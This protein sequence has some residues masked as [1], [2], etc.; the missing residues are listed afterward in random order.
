MTIHVNKIAELGGHKGAV[1]TLEPA[2][3]PNLFFSGSSDRVSALWD[4]GTNEPTGF[5]AQFPSIVF[6]LC[7][8]KGKNLLLTGTSNGSL[9]F[10]NLDKK[11][12]IKIIQLTESGTNKHIPGIFDIKFHE[13]SGRIFCAGGDGTFS[14]C[15]LATMSMVKIRKLCTEKTRCIEINEARKEIAVGCGDGVIWIFDLHTLEEKKHF[16]AHKLSANAVKYDP[17]GRFLLSG[18]RDAHLR[19]WD[20]ENGF[21]NVRSIPAHNFAIY[22]IVFN[23]AG[24]LFATASRDSSI[25]IWDARTFELLKVINKDKFP[26]HK[27][28]IDKLLWS[29]YKN[30]LVS[31]GDDRMIML[32]DVKNL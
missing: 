6:S 22:S 16:E 31:S 17:S 21:E 5:G 8:I 3:E 7:Y 18:G 15:D 1:Y 23:P 30:I 4:L 29:D 28:S 32:W 27:S 24:D 20:A 12:E 2:R 13:P 25:K 10:I 26:S 14:V 9:H 11:E 19:V